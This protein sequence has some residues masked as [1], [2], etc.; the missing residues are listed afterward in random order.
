MQTFCSS[1]N[2]IHQSIPLFQMHFMFLFFLLKNHKKSIT[3]STNF[4]TMPSHSFL[5]HQSKSKQSFL[6]RHLSVLISIGHI[7]ISFGMHMMRLILFQ[8]SNGL[9]H[10]QKYKSVGFLARCR[11]YHLSTPMWLWI[12]HS[13]TRQNTD[14]TRLPYI[15][16]LPSQY[17]HSLKL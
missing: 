1:V 8:E 9:W 15:H 12:L 7:L 2:F 3:N 5:V 11:C 17:D 6:C 16:V 13:I 4:C 14:Q 10:Q